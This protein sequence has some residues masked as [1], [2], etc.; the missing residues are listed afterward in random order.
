[1]RQR[2]DLA[3]AEFCF[4]ESLL[5]ETLLERVVRG[6]VVLSC[7]A[8]VGRQPGEFCEPEPGPAKLPLTGDRA[9]R[10]RDGRGAG[11]VVAGQLILTREPVAVGPAIVQHRLAEGIRRVP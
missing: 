9:A 6:A 10:A 5:V 8:V 3:D 7:L 1:M 11:V 2:A 4:D